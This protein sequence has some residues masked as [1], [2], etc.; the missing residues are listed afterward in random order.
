MG[1]WG[2][3]VVGVVFLGPFDA[4]GEFFE[5]A[6]A[7][8]FSGFDAGDLVLELGIEEEDGIGYLCKKGKC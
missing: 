5:A 3:I 4:F 7:V 1:W 6:F 2:A 8:D